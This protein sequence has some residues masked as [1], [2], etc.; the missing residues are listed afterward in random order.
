MASTIAEYRRRRERMTE[1]LG[2]KCA[3]CGSISNLQIDHVDR[4]SKSFDVSQ[5]WSSSWEMLVTELD[6][7]QLL[8]RAH[9]IEKTR[10]SG[11]HAGGHNKWTEVQHGRVWAYAKYGCR[12][13]ICVEVY[14]HSRRKQP[15]Q[16]A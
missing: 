13:A 11:D 5:N 7:C 8:C 3:V 6:K 15:V 2:G 10:V 12:C 16:A 4:A 1:Y 9:H 14:R